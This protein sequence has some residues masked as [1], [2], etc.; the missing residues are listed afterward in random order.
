MRERVRIMG[1]V[2]FSKDT[3]V[4]NER[5]LIIDLRNGFL[6]KTVILFVFVKS[7]MFT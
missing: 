3:H 1:V 2:I 6:H 5:N 4:L 7:Y